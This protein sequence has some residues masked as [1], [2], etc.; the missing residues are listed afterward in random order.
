MIVDSPGVGDEMDEMVIQYL[1]AAFAFIYVAN[2]ANA[3]G[4]QNDRVSTWINVSPFRRFIRMLKAFIPSYYVKK[5][6]SLQSGLNTG[7][8][9]S[10]PKLPR[11][12]ILFCILRTI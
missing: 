1:P 11:V 9:S 3:G 7:G 6:G 8:P 12:S 5:T 2:S 4:V 10:V